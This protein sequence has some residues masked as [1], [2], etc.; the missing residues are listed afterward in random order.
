M[1]ELS[2]ALFCHLEGLFKV[3]FS[4]D[5]ELSSVDI[6]PLGIDM[7]GFE[8]CAPTVDEHLLELSHTGIKDRILLICRDLHKV[9]GLGVSLS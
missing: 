9:I 3:F 4:R 5:R 7:C 8:T 6:A 1:L 2:I